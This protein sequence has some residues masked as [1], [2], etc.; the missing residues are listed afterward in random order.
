MYL[1]VVLT[2][3]PLAQGHEAFLIANSNTVMRTVN[4]ELIKAVFPN[5]PYTP[6]DASNPNETLLSIAK[7]RKMLG[8]EPR[9]NW[10]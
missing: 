8:F 7:A 1:L 9:H 2:F 3:R 6:V 5:V 10:K 4:K